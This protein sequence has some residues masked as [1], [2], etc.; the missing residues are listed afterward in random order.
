MNKLHLLAAAIV[1]LVTGCLSVKAEGPRHPNR[2]EWIGRISGVV[3]DCDQRA[4]EFR[5]ALARA[6]D[7][8]RLAGTD[9]AD[10]LNAD[11]QALDHAIG[12][13]RESWNRDRDPERSRMHVRAAVDAARQINWTLEHHRL[14]GQIQRE[15]DV[16]RSELNLLAEI[17]D[18][19]HIRW[20][21]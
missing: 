18:E 7:R 19:P 1:T 11:A 17:F 13:L 6:M 15:W 4:G 20:E 12:R 14:R 21:R 3:R 9:K 16:L 10:R 8:S 5:I 2:A